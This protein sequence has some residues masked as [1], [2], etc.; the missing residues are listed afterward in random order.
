MSSKRQYSGAPRLITG[1]F[2]ATA[3]AQ[4]RQVA[5][6]RLASPSVNQAIG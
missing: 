3:P 1:D 5:W 2:E 6:N 4:R